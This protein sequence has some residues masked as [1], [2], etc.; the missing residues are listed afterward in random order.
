MLCVVV[1]VISFLNAIV[2]LY[3]ISTQ[4]ENMRF[5]SKMICCI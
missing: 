5:A 1:N 2:Q 3:S 4:K